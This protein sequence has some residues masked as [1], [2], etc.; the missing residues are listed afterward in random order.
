MTLGSAD[1]TRDFFADFD[2]D[3]RAI[4][5]PD[6]VLYAAFGLQRGTA[7]Q[8]MS[9]SVFSAGLRAV[10]KGN[11]I[12]MPVGDVRQL[13]GEFLVRAGRIEWAHRAADVGD[14]PSF[15]EIARAFASMP[16]A[17]R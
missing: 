3:A 15:D 13:S 16:A 10:L 1:A 14:H 5:D 6:K 9:T 2:P 4:A 11:G 7:G 12:G 17:S 8:L